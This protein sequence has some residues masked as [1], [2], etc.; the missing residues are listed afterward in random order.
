MNA[1]LAGNQNSGK[2]TL[3]NRLTGNNAHAGNFPGVTVDIS[4]G[5]IKGSGIELFDLPGIYSLSSFS[6]EEELARKAIENSPDLI[7]NIVDAN[8]LDRGLYLTLQLARY[9]IKM[10]VALNMI[11]EVEKRGGR[12][13]VASLEK[14]LGVPVFPI[15]ARSGR[16][17][18]KLLQAIKSDAGQ[19]CRIRIH[20]QADFEAQAE[21][22]YRAVDALARHADIPQNFTSS[23]AD[24]ILLGKYTAIPCFLLILSAILFLTF[25][26]FGKFA[27]GFIDLLFS[28]ISQKLGGLLVSFGASD[29]VVRLVCDGILSGIGSIISFLPC[30]LI[31]FFFLALL[32]D[33][34]YMA[35]IAF[36]ADAPMHACGLSGKAIVPLLLGLGCSVPALLSCRTLEEN[37]K[38]TA[39]AVPFIACSA[40]LPVFLMLS[41]YLAH[42]FLMIGILY[43]LGFI[44]A[45]LL[46]ITLSGST[47]PPFL[48]EIPPYR[49]PKLSSVFKDMTDK[50]FDFLKRAFT[51]I[52]IASLA[53]WLLSNITPSFGLSCENSILCVLS[54]KL[55]PLFVPLG[56]TSWK[57][58][59]ALLS[60]ISAKEA[61]LSSFSVLDVSLQTFTA[62][63]AVSFLVFSALY[64]PCIASLA[65]IKKEYGLKSAVF[66]CCVQTLTAYAAAFIAYTLMQLV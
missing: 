3:F 12:I 47:P 41:K 13:D 11:D 53:V 4:K 37:R 59:A 65:L 35:R 6:A 34:G 57:L 28:L 18:D 26:V 1:L 48:I 42:P 38:N 64:T 31:L 51:I 66:S 5:R 9:G 29:F 40:R 58:P 50:A 24:R 19:I 20:E 46:G 36:I 60:G 2:T 56:F 52:F 43:L 15:S 54:K 17:C 32:E 55:L 62:S 44:C 25:S 39:L 63:S 61:I 21:E 33:S 49:L 30:V 7:I 10:I 14:E 22:Y 23:F 45:L 27:C 8:S 16:G